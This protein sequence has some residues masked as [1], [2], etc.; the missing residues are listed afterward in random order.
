MDV[1]GLEYA[2][3]LVERLNLRLEAASRFR[4][5]SWTTRFT[6]E[7]FLASRLPSGP[8]SIA[9]VFGSGFFLANARRD[10]FWSDSSQPRFRT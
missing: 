9:G 5:A 4:R 7:L 8:F 3:F 1:E 6:C 10:V 2:G